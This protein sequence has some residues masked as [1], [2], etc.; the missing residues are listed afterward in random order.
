MTLSQ[1]LSPSLRD[2]V[3]RCLTRVLPLFVLTV[4]SAPLYAATFTVNDLGDAQDAIPSDGICA[5]AD[6][7]CQQTM[8]AVLVIFTAISPPAPF[9][10]KKEKAIFQ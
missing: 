9:P 1:L 2:L 7:V 8:V 3:G 6:V 4:L 10:M 5:T